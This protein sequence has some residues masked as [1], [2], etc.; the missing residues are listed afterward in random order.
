MIAIFLLPFSAWGYSEDECIRCH[1]S[2]STESRLQMD[3]GIYRTSIHAG[4]IKCTDCHSAIAGDEHFSDKGLE[5]VNCRNCHGQ[6]ILH[7]QNGSI[8]CTDCHTRHAIY[9]ADDL[10][11]SVNWRNLVKSCGGCH[12]EQT[13]SPSGL[14]MLTSFQIVSHPKQNM[15]EQVNKAMCVGCHQGKA[16]HGEQGPINKQNCYKCHYP[17]DKKRI[18]LGYMHPYADWQ[19]KPVNT[20]AGCLSMIVFIGVILLAAK[21]FMGHLTKRRNDHDGGKY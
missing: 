21:E 4:E 20:A 2:G 3:I 19:K 13:K 5:K 17:M 6:R 1:R 8:R 15:A 11:S 7:G 9:K 14:S 12:P 16:A 10:R 18:L